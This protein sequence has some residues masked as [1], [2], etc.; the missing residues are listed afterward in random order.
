MRGYRF[1]ETSSQ[2]CSISI[3][4]TY[5]VFFVVC[6]MSDNFIF[7]ILFTFFCMWVKLG[8][9]MCMLRKRCEGG[10]QPKIKLTLS[11]YLLEAREV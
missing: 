2:T 9:R 1:C 4:Y 3:T 7:K 8:L 11:H 6:S 5:R 10:L